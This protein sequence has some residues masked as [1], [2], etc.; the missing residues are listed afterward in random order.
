[1]KF[2]VVSDECFDDPGSTIELSIGERDGWSLLRK[3]AH[4][5]RAEGDVASLAKYEA[6]LTW[7]QQAKNFSKAVNEYER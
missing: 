6:S 3:V 2:T 5:T 4:A 1:M 7:L